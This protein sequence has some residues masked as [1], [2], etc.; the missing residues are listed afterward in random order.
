MNK[1][2]ANLECIGNSEPLSY[3]NRVQPNMAHT[4]VTEEH[5]YCSL[6]TLS[7]ST[8]KSQ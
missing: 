7:G 3:N 4:R 1:L 8:P 2:A 6:P 5:N